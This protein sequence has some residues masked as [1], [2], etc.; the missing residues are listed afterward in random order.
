MYAESVAKHAAFFVALQWA[1]CFVVNRL[2]N[3]WYKGKQVVRAASRIAHIVFSAAVSYCAIGRMLE[4]GMLWG[5]DDFSETNARPLTP[6]DEWIASY[7]V[8]YFVVD[9]FYLFIYELGQ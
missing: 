9:V 4:M 3:P 2:P 8:A 1:F 5:V 7:S 6:L